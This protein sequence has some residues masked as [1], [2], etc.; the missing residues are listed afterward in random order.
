MSNH[1]PKSVRKAVFERC[2]AM[3]TEENNFLSSAKI[4]DQV[5]NTNAQ[6]KPAV[7]AGVL[8]ELD[9]QSLL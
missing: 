9:R 7:C 4:S 5:Q 8:K 3:L 6:N 2:A 1:F